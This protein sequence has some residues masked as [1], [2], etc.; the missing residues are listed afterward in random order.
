M[1]KS[2]LVPDKISYKENKNLDDNDLGH[3]SSVYEYNLFGKDVEIVLG[4]QN[5]SFSRHDIVYYPV[6]LVVNDELKEKIGVLEASTK[7][8]ISWID[9][10]GD[11]TIHPENMIIYATQEH[12][13]KILSETK[14]ITDAVRDEIDE[15]EKNKTA[16]SSDNGADGDDSSEDELFEPS[17]DIT[18]LHIPQNKISTSFKTASVK[19][20]DGIFKIN[21]NTKIPESLPEETKADAETNK[22]DYRE[23]KDIPWIQKFMKNNKYDIIDNEGG[24]DCFFAVIRDA[25]KQIG[26]DTTV[27]KLRSLIAKETTDAQFT[28]HRKL[29]TGFLSEY[30]NKEG[31]IK[32]IKHKISILKKRA[33]ENAKNKVE[34]KMILEEANALVKK[35]A[36]L[37]IEKDDAKELLDEFKYM[38]SVDTLDKFRDFIMT[39]KYWADDG[40]ISTLERLLNIKVIIFSEEAYDNG[41]LDTVLNCGQLQEH[42]VENQGRSP[43]FYIMTSYTGNHYKLISYKEKNIFAFKEIPYDV[44]ALVINK[45]LEKNAGPY[46]IIEDFRKLKTHLGLDPNEGEPNEEEDEYLTRDLYDKDIVFVFHSTSNGKPKAGLGSGETIPENNRIDFPTLNK[47]K[48]WRRK[49]DDS[50]MVPITMD[51]HRWNSVEHYYLGSQYKKGFP[52]FYLKFSVESGSDIS[53][54]ITIAKAACSKSGKMAIKGAEVS[55]REK[56]VKPDA[57]FYE[58]GKSPRNKIERENALRAKFTQNLDLKNILL[59]TKMAKLVHFLRGKEPETDE[60]LMQ[61]R[62]EIATTGGTN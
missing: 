52:D 10:T 14:P 58:M 55:L 9:D 17:D 27:E 34:Q 4:K 43:D 11:I 31:E 45:C 18:S 1:V 54:D 50:W 8:I 57:D 7:D 33:D 48:D 62:K 20:D 51:G 2:K 16:K 19:T 38:E 32:D 29:Y 56:N 47:T 25:F 28:E 23:S 5:T 41:D 42:D 21:S 44:K 30:K 59:G 46:Y 60:L 13:A 3:A 40:S 35:H 61:I 37:V 49:L 53:K 12:L 15:I 26:K 36:E 39:S 6:Y 22:I 24:G